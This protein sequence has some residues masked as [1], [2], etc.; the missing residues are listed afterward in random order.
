M[1][2]LLLV[3]YYTIFWSYSVRLNRHVLHASFSTYP[4]RPQT[5][6][7]QRETRTSNPLVCTLWMLYS[8]PLLH[9]VG[10]LVIH[11][12]PFPA[13]GIFEGS[14]GVQIW[15]ST[16]WACIRTIRYWFLLCQNNF[17]NSHLFKTTRCACVRKNVGF[18]VTLVRLRNV[19]HLLTTLMW[20]LAVS[21]TS[22]TA[23]ML[24]PGMKRQVVGFKCTDVSEHAF[25]TFPCD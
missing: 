21:F 20:D 14:K 19:F 11:S 23:K 8:Q 3:I 18:W 13:N 15:G 10:K 7:R 1:T 9:F 4:H 6:L 12:K 16:I 24:Y 22:V 17:N 5:A 2:L 25:I